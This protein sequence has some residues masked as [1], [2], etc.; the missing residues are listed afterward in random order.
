MK[1]FPPLKASLP[2][3]PALKGGGKMERDRTSSPGAATILPSAPH[4]AVFLDP[5]RV[6]GYER[7]RVMKAG[8]TLY[9]VMID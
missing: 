8:E 2:Q 3:P 9:A 6:S 7:Y 4:A 1:N 5:V